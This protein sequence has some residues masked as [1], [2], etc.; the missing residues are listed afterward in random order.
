M[1]NL[2]FG[3]ILDIEKGLLDFQ[4]QAHELAR[5]AKRTAVETL[6]LLDADLPIEEKCS[7]VRASIEQTSEQTTY[8]ITNMGRVD[9]PFSLEQHVKELYPCLPTAVNPF[10]LA[11]VSYREAGGAECGAARPRHGRMRTFCGAL[12]GF[13]IPGRKFKVCSFHMMRYGE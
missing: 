2:S 12:N 7:L 10:T 9:L 8:V 3:D 1:A 13:D 11:L 6:Q 5:D 4:T